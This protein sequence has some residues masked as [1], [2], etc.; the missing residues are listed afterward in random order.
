MSYLASVSQSEQSGRARTAAYLHEIWR[1]ANGDPDYLRALRFSGVGVLPSVFPVTDFAS[2]AI[3]AAS[4]AVAELVHRATGKLP[5]VHVD[6]RRAS[7]WFGTSLRPCGWQ[8]PPPWDLIAG[9]YRSADGWIR[10]HTNAP[11]HRDAAL[12]VL[13]TP[14]DKAAVARAVEQWRGDALES[15][16]IAQGGCAAAMHTQDEW[17]RHPQGR[18]VRAEPLL[19]HDDVAV[20]GKR[21]AWSAPAERP[22]HGVRVLDLTRILAGPVATRFLAGFGAQVLRIDPIGWDEP[23]TVPEVVLGKRCARADLK[24]GEGRALLRRLIGEADVMVHGYRPDA[25][26][27]LGFDA[28]ER[29]RINPGLVDVSLDAYGWSGPW[30]GRRGFDSL[31]QTSAG[32]VKTGMRETRG[33]RP[34]PLPVQALDHGTGYFLATAAIRGLA[35]RLAT[36]VGTRTRASL[37][38]TAV[39]LASDGLQGKDRRTIAPEMPDDLA[40]WVEETSWGPAQRVRAPVAVDGAPVRWPHPASALGS[41][42][43]EW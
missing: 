37:A 9:D 4:A 18:A 11:H 20:E 7:L 2:A 30:R 35:R 17:A 8:V 24:S 5:V 21:P 3:G 34:V 32:I 1:A 22:L 10:L 14:L 42:P 19:I 23:N 26:E 6:R 12:A 27:R 41:S 28:D 29:R 43:A 31:V 40:E 16:V 39:L 15:A 33:E 36:G 25:L 38:R 13:G